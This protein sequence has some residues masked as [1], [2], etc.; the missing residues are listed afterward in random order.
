MKKTT[1]QLEID[2]FAKALEVFAK[3]KNKPQIQTWLNN[4]NKT[5]TKHSR[6]QED[7]TEQIK[8]C[9]D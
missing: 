1:R 7:N 4:N 3:I 2:A 8:L 5:T 9:V 6:V